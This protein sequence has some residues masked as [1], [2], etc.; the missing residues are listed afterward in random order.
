[1]LVITRKAGEG[2]YVGD[3]VFVKV[4]SIRGSQVRFGFDAPRSV[5][6]LREEMVKDGTKG[7]EVKPTVEA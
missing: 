6:I 2:I 4:L 1:M 5:V 3:N 7:Q